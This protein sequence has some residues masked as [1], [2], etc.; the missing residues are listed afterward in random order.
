MPLPRLPRTGRTTRPARG[1]TTRFTSAA[2]AVLVVLAAAGCSAEAADGEKRQKIDFG[3]IADYNQAGLLAIAEKRGLWAKHG[4]DAS[5]KVFTDGPTQITALGAGDLD[6]GTIGPGATWLPASGKATV[7]A[8]NQLGQADRVVAL[9]GKGIRTIADLKGREVAVPEGTSGDMIL[10]LALKK[11][12]LTRQDVQV[13]PMAPPTAV[14]A[15]ASGKIDA[16]ALWHPLLGTVEKRVPDLVELAKSADFAE[17]FVFPS[18]VVASPKTVKE[19]P[20]LVTDVNRVLQEANDIRHRDRAESVRITAG[21]LRLDERAVA[22]DA[23]NTQPLS[24]ADLL[25]KTEDGTV[26][27]WYAALQE[28]FVSTGKLDGPA[29]P[30]SFYAGG[31]YTKAADGK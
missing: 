1:R 12:G 26:A 23:R 29:R 10:T 22:E 31:L 15:L 17:K 24:T 14:A 11:A 7:I 5:Y 16:A 8:V 18:S 27:R 13:V 30:G 28:F 6:F 2:A 3:Y 4:L 21:F 25:K 19:R 20:G 9:P